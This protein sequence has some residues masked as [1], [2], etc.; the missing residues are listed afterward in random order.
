MRKKPEDEKNEEIINSKVHKIWNQRG[1]KQLGN[2]IVSAR[3]CQAHS[4]NAVKM[5]LEY[6]FPHCITSGIRNIWPQ[7]IP[8]FKGIF[9]RRTGLIILKP[10]E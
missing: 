8:D 4:T 2:H 9:I 5:S 3:Q 1:F 7:R 10:F 6:T